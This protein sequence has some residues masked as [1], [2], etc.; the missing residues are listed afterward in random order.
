VVIH[1]EGHDAPAPVAGETV[2]SRELI[3]LQHEFNG[4][5]VAKAGISPVL[6]SR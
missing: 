5:K 3:R 4:E 2:R 6:L 1:L